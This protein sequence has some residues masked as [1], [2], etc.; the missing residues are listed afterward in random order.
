MQAI[1][2]K[3][4]AVEVQ[5]A[6]P[7]SEKVEPEKMTDSTLPKAKKDEDKAPCE[8]TDAKVICPEETK[9]AE[10]GDDDSSLRLDKK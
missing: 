5:Q 1:R 10:N 4:K 2:D 9:C 7:V 3:H 8:T 6:A